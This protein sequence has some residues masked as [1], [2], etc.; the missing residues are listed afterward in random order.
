MIIEW[1]GDTTG[2][3]VVDGWL[4][5]VSDT[6]LT[7]ADLIGATF[8]EN[9][10]VTTPVS[11]ANISEGDGYIAIEDGMLVIVSEENA[12]FAEMTFPATGICFEG[13]LTTE[14]GDEF[15]AKFETTV[16]GNVESSPRICQ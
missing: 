9:T 14:Y 2:L 16:T 3:I 7:T 6:V 11:A 10:E 8:T 12:V 5:K 1:D 4:Y 13:H 15:I